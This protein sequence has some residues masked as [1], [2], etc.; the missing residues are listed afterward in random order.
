MILLFKYLNDVVNVFG[1]VLKSFGDSQR[2][3]PDQ[4]I[5]FHF[6]L[7]F[8]VI[9]VKTGNWCVFISDQIRLLWSRCNISQLK[10]VLFILITIESEHGL[11]NT[12]FR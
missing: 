7:F 10:F 9:D 8:N 4:G 5:V 12:P 11:L 1:S 3:N 2:S 6:L